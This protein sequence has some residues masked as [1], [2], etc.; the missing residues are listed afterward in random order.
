MLPNKKTNAFAAI[1]KQWRSSPLEPNALR[2][3]IKGCRMIG[4]PP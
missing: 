4:P 2:P 1:E 3:K